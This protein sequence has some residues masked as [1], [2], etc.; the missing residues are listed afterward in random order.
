[1]MRIILVSLMML[2]MVF[3]SNKHIFSYLDSCKKSNF[4]ALKV[5]LK[6]KPK[7]DIYD[8]DGDTPLTKIAKNL[9]NC[10]YNQDLAKIII[11]S[12][13]IIDLPNKVGD[14]PLISSL[15]KDKDIYF[16][17]FLISEGADI[18]KPSKKDRK[19]PLMIAAKNANAE[20]VRALSERFAKR[21]ARDKS[22]KSAFDYAIASG[23]E[24]IVQKVY[25]DKR[26]KFAFL[27][28]KGKALFINLAKKG[29]HV[30]DKV[31][32]SKKILFLYTDK[33]IYDKLCTMIK[34]DIEYLVVINYDEK[35]SDYKR[36]RSNIKILKFNKEFYELLLKALRWRTPPMFLLRDKKGDIIKSGID[37]KSLFKI[38]R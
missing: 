22:G 35:I 1:M 36:C 27:D 26:G 4:N 9:P 29:F 15:R 7:L 14:T 21:G 30:K 11:D 13:N 3:A 8:K 31:L 10:Y 34:K 6:T 25:A 37:E 23:D 16:S 18:N 38:N 20:M 24:E 17:K 12:S 5:I 19:T 32:D 33:K 2:S 28:S